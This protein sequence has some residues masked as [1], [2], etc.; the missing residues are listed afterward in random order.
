[1]AELPRFFLPGEDFSPTEIHFSDDVLHHL[2]T[3]LRLT[4][5]SEAI[6]L[7]GTGHCCR[8]R[9]TRLDRKRGT[10]Q[11]LQ[12]WQTAETALPI[13]LV[14]ALPKGDK[15]DLVLQ[16]GTELGISAFHPVLTKRSVAL[17][18]R[19]RSEQRQQRWQRIVQEAARQSR[20]S[21]LPQLT[22]LSPLESV[23]E[24]RP[25]G[26]R[27]VLWEAGAKPLAEALPSTSPSEVTI[28]IGPEGGFDP[29]EIDLI[30]AYGFIPVH[31]GPRILR[32]E[33][34]GL[35]VTSILQYLYGDMHK[36]PAE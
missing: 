24:A 33:T 23:L 14:Q 35:A 32:T 26:L 7:D 3:V 15:F 2:H 11:V 27:L 1:M 22:P 21:H 8:V 9:I 30:A 19:Q 28:L 25:Q 29:G 12:R 6:F 34:T 17:P 5:D 16:K 31:L 13:H 4:V 10:A 20:R 36:T 18:D